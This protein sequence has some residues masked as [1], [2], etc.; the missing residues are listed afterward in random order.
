MI[1]ETRI[2]VQV[3]M[4]EWQVV[5][6]AVILHCQL[7]V[8]IQREADGAVLAGMDKRGLEF[9]PALDQRCRRTFKGRGH[10][11]D[12]HENDIAPDV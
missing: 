4:N 8:T 2:G 9:L 10:A 3:G 12:I 5:G 11:A 6:F 7:P 1:L